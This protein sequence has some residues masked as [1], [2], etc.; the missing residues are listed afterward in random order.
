MERQIIAKTIFE[1]L[2]EEGINARLNKAGD[3]VE[4]EEKDTDRVFEIINRKRAEMLHK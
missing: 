1:W 2:T 4:F 3:N